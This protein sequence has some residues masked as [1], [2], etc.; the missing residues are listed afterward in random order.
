MNNYELLEPDLVEIAEKSILKI[1]ERFNLKNV[2]IEEAFNS[3][4][5]YKPT[6]HWK[7]KTHIIVCEIASSPFPD[8]IK[9]FYSEI[10]VKGL[11]V[12]I[13]IAYPINRQINITEYNKQLNKAK[14]YGIGLISLDENGL[15]EL[16][17]IGLSIPLH[18]P[19]ITLTKYKKNLR[20]SIEDAYSVYING[21]PR[22]GVQELGQIIEQTIRNLAIQAKR[23]GHYTD[24]VN[25][26]LPASSF[27]TIIDDL[28]R[29][30]ILSRTF[31]NRVRA[32]TEDRNSVSHRVNSIKQSIII[33]NKLKL[34]FQ[35]GLRILEEIPSI[36]NSGKNGFKYKV[37]II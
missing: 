2:K 5:N 12:K 23:L 17:N 26:N 15:A 22:H 20:H 14:E 25:P 10:V 13:I 28:I 31:L 18:I 3:E 19:K 27:A 11:P 36:F 7:T 8:S 16:E 30:S 29:N 1:Q 32:Y 34:D 4:I 24:G 35:T 37:K 9:Y 6:L 33:E 21:N